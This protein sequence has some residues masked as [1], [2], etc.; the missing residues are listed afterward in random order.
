[1]SKF[2]TKIALF[3]YFWVRILKNYCHIWNQ[4]PRI[5]LIAKY[6]KKRNKTKKIE[7]KIALF[8]HFWARILKKYCHIW[9]QHPRICPKAKF[10]KKRHLSNFGTINP[11]FGYFWARIEKAI[12][13]SEISSLEFLK[14]ESLTHTVNFGIRS[15]FSGFGFLKVWVRVRVR[16]IKYAHNNLQSHSPFV[17]EN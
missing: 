3:G 1:M 4:Y 5:C 16:F 15:A 2:G 9:H 11:L 17:R 8:G 10:C 13:I 12:V 7:T 6:H 14:N